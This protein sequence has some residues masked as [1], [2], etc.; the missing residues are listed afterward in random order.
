M[1]NRKLIVDRL[2][3]HVGEV[4]SFTDG[5]PRD[6]LRARPAPTTWSLFEIAMH[7]AE[8][9]DIH[10]ER[11]TRMLAEENPKITPFA[12][13]KERQEGLYFS[14]NFERR[15]RDFE[16]QRRNLFALL[17]DLDDAQWR[18]EG[19][20]PEVKHYTIEKCVEAMMRHEEHH[21]LQMFNVFFGVRE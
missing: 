3:Q 21:L 17:K 10:V 13:D 7:L 6:E 8:V 19:I 12:P 5:L 16:E 14:Q 1:D 11:V 15:M 4:R 20:H 2:A 9:Q 18:R